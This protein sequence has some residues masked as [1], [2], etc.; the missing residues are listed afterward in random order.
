MQ[1]KLTLHVHVYRYTK[2][3]TATV[4][5]VVTIYIYIYK[6]EQFQRNKYCPILDLIAPT[7]IFK[8]F[9]SLDSTTTTTSTR[10]SFLNVI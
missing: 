7:Y 10:F 8:Q 1:L 5:T 6:N 3:G 4:G 9:Y 2:V